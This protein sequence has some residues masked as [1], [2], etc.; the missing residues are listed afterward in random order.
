MA[1]M[2][3]V[4]KR[5]TARN[6]I[7]V[8]GWTVVSRVVGLLRVLVIGAVMGPTFLANVFQAAYVLGGNVFTVLAGPVLAMVV[9]PTVVNAL[10][11]GGAERATE[12]LG[13]VAARLLAIATA[14]AAA[15][16]VASP[17]VAWLLVLGVPR[18]DQGR[19]WLITTILILFMAPQVLL[20]TVSG[21]AVA[22]QQARGRF[23]LPAAAAGVESIGAIVTVLLSAWIFGA[24]LEVGR[25]PIAMIVLLGAGSTGS[26]LLLAA[27][28]VCGATRAGVSTRPRRGW[29]AD[30]EAR[31]SMRRMSRSVPVAASPVATSFLLTTIAATVPGGV[32]VI[33]L[34]YQVFYGLS[35]VGARAV[36][37]AA[38]PT[39][40]EAAST[41]DDAR[42]AAAWRQGLHYAV[43][44]SLPSLGLL[45]VFAWPT[46]NLLANG[47]LRAGNVIGMLALCLS[48][49]AVAQ[50]I[51]G[52]HDL[53]R[54]ALFA[55]LDD[56]GPRSASYV[57][58]LVGVIVGTGALLLPV[59]GSRLVCLAAAIL[60]A[61]LAAAITVVHRLRRAIRPH[62]FVDSQQAA[63]T[64]A[65]CLAMLPVIAAGKWTL[66]AL[67]LERI[68]QLALL[69]GIG[70]LSLAA[71]GLTLWGLG[72]R[73]PPLR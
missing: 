30:P 14:G 12:L 3:Q 68:L 13:H 4:E 47:E 42:F 61:E 67:H 8:A 66:D 38:L 58:L 52:V 15:L 41:R 37:M 48:V 16:A 26:V 6:S 62:R 53:G 9:V 60:A 57:A 50:L 39:L 22:A 7:T 10:S 33:Q 19:A 29:R 54:Q 11:A 25:A 56:R 27:L 45:A 21:V 71:Y 49:V 72:R 20:Y 32:L 46:A 35:F 40:A 28:Q 59:G 23:A 51:G 65:G 63:H 55:R 69:L 1:R 34:S 5:S 2:G 43:T 64:A 73:I 44:V 70:S 17:G 24:G 31:A 18:P 36:S